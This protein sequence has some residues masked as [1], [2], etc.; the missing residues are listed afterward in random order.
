MPFNDIDVLVAS[1]VHLRYA[2]EHMD[3]EQ[4]DGVHRDELEA[5]TAPWDQSVEPV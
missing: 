3:A 1:K 5:M 4:V 2:A